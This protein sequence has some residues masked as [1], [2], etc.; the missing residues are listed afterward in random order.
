MKFIY[1]HQ[2]FFQIK[3]KDKTTKAPPTVKG[4]QFQL[5]IFKNFSFAKLFD[6]LLELPPT[7]PEASTIAS[8]TSTLG[9]DTTTLGGDTTTIS[10]TTTTA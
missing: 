10:E 3:L 9:D 5:S 2:F 4:L 8:E 1:F 6:L 7:A